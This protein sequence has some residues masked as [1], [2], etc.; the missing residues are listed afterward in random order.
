M[1]LS[2]ADLDFDAIVIGAGISGLYQLYKLRELGFR[3]RVFERGTG[4]GGTWYWNRYPGA[5]F[6]SESYSY[7]Y[8]FSQELLDEWN[9]SEHFAS[10]PE[11]LRYLQHVA[12][13]F[14]LR[15]DIQFS[16]TVKSAVYDDGTRSWQVQ[17]QDG[18]SYQSRFLITGIGNFSQPTL[19]KIEGID[20][21]GGKSFHTSRW[22]HTP[23]NF[24]GERVAV[25]G[26]G[27][28]G[29]QTIQEVSKDVGH[30]TVFQRRPNWCA[31]L[32]N[33]EIELDEM[34]VIRAGYDAMFE[35]CAQTQSGF[36]HTADPRGTFEVTIEERYEFWEQLY[37][38]PGFGI[39]QGN[40]KD[41]LTDPEANRAISDFI[42]DK[43]R[44]RVNDPL[45]A[46]KLI[47]K[48]HGFGTRRVPL[49]TKY[50]ES[51]NQEN[52]EL[53]DINETPIERITQNGILT[54]EKALEF[55]FIIYATGFDAVFG[56]YDEID[57]RGVN[58]RKLKDQW[59]EEL[60]TF[61]GIQTHNF[62]NLFMILGPHAK[63]GNNPRNI[64]YN[65]EWITEVIRHMNDR[66]LTRAEVSLEAQ[67]S[68]HEYVVEQ[69]KNLLWRQV[70]SW[71]TGV[72]SN[73][74]GRQTRI[75]AQYSGGLQSFRSRCE[76]VAQ[77]G[78]KELNLT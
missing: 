71:M 38:S 32:H 74:E 52:V 34:E 30:L 12:D 56:S 4:V 22:P 10:Q 23:V 15:K 16:S 75:V 11:I 39:W 31:P 42:A 28:T 51:Y 54:T 45:V 40:F 25:I 33:S 14:D 53:I 29:V 77:N 60:A 13:K 44:E 9:W 41:I 8:S 1:V 66:G 26:T 7:G 35:R 21:F 61:M 72:N 2:K 48:N 58:Q 37:A 73:L 63:Q 68:W 70:D 57:I 20:S 6:D 59:K 67:D 47:P 65:V 76:E 3:V 18:N 17:L 49:E 43:I 69:S 64:E 27:A 19:P 78:Y 46:E 55:D 36:I 62:P 50:Y 5:R 24:A